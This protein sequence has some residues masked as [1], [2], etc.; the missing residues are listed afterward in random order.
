MGDRSTI[1]G[2]AGAF[3]MGVIIIAG[4]Y[5]LG[6]KNNPIVPQASA[7]YQATLTNLFK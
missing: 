2:V 6:Q 5:Q 3:L 4:I 1:I 7:S